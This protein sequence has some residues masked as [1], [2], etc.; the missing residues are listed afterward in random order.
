VDLWSNP[1]DIV[2]T[3]FLGIGSEVWAAVQAGR[4]GIGFELKET[5]FRQAKVNM[6]R[7]MIGAETGAL[8]QFAAGE[9][10]SVAENDDA[11]LEAA[12]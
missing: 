2:F 12:S 11:D 1:G 6:T 9:Q 8:E 3:P 4:R 7:E 10:P 5:Y